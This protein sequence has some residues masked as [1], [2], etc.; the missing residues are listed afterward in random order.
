MITIKLI[1]D[2]DFEVTVKLKSTTQHVVHVSNNFYK[3]L[4]DGKVSCEHLIKSSFEFLLERESNN[5]ILSQFDLEV[6]SHYFPEY[7]KEI[8]KRLKR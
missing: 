4:T 7:E 2:S 1:E 3:L 6:I 5:S 8:K